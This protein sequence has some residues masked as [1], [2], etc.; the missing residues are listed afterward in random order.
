MKNPNNFKK[1]NV[2]VQTIVLPKDY[3][4]P[5]VAITH[6]LETIEYPKIFTIPHNIFALLTVTTAII[7]FNQRICYLGKDSKKRLKVMTFVLP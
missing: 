3:I 2:G 4:P 7:Y 5:S 6:N 1:R